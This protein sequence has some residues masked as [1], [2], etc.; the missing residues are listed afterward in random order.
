M[1]RLVSSALSILQD[2]LLRGTTQPQ[3][4][5]PLVT[6]VQRKYYLPLRGEK[7]DFECKLQRLWLQRKETV[8]WD[9]EEAA[10]KVFDLHISQK[11]TE[12]VNNCLLQY[13]LTVNKEQ[14]NHFITHV[15]NCFCFLTRHGIDNWRENESPFEGH[16]EV[17]HPSTRVWRKTSIART[18]KNIY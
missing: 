14:F 1:W 11:A 7:V 18:D 9:E 13:Q 15:H 10:E 6:L 17:R 3:M 4:K 8:V 16:T 2:H 5:W 12:N